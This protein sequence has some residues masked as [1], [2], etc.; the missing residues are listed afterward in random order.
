MGITASLRLSSPRSCK[1]FGRLSA[2]SQIPS[3]DIWAFASALERSQEFL[4]AVG[5]GSEA[6]GGFFGRLTRLL[7]SFLDAL[8]RSGTV[9]EASRSSGTTREG[10]NTT[11]VMVWRLPP[12][13]TRARELQIGCPGR[14]HRTYKFNKITI[15]ISLQRL[16]A[17]LS[18]VHLHASRLKAS[19][20]S[21]P[22]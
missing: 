20:D 3:T 18:V 1:R 8:G 2:F 4:E 19:A 7:E 9:P 11:P 5:S 15:L 10:S 22:A 6:S 14:A 17:Q 12:R 13:P 21:C 16:Q